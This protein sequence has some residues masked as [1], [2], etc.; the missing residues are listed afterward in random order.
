MRT[1]LLSI[2]FFLKQIIEILSAQPLS[3]ARVQQ[4]IRYGNMMNSQLE[5]LQSF[6]EDLLD[7][8]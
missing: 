5:F 2:L 4:G 6:I 3:Y 8:R 7:L 1:P